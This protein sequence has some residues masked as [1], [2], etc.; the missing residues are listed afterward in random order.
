MGLTQEILKELLKYDHDTG[1]LY[2]AVRPRKY[3]NSD[4][5]YKSWNARFSGKEVCL[6]KDRLGY[7]KLKIFKNQYSA[8]RL[9]WLFVHGEHASSIDHI[10]MG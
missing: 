3:F 2:W 5:H 10:N 8:H 9:I 6:Y 7:L 4:L 1:K